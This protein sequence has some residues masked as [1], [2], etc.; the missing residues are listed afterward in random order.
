MATR[1][2]LRKQQKLEERQKALREMRAQQNLYRVKF[3]WKKLAIPVV[4]VAILILLIWLIPK[5]IIWLGERGRVSGP[6]GVIP[7]QE[8]NISNFATLVTSDGDIKVELL[9]KIS[10]KTVANFVLL[11]NKD[12]Y[13]GVTFHRVIKDF[14]IQTGDPLSRDDDPGNDGTGGPDYVFDDEINSKTP[15]LVQGMM[16]MANSGTGPD[17]AGTNGSQFF[18]ITGESTPWLDGKHTPFGRVV[19]GMDIVSKIDETPTVDPGVN[20]RPIQDIIVRDIIISES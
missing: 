17:G 1:Q 9:N 5:G 15:K 14:M 19:Y 10:P 18:I 4:S 11:A 2:K 3:P 7:T 12:F 16:A 20:D 8:L 13:D 6:F